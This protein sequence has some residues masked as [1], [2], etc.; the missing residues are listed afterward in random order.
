MSLR[1]TPGRAL[2]RD[3]QPRQ[4]DRLDLAGEGAADPLLGLLALD[5]GE[6]ADGAEVDAEDRDAGAGEAA[7]RVQDR[8][9]AAEDDAEVG[10]RLVA[11]DRLDAR[12]RVAVLGELVRGGDQ[13]PAGLG[14]DRG[15]DRHGLGGGRRV[16][17]GDQGRGL[18]R[19]T[20]T[21]A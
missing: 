12:G 9:V 11:G 4:L 8:A 2:Q 14:G 20:S 7:Q 5:R 18:H 6:E 15:G 13:P 16:R 10:A 3:L 21:A 1:P 19:S 17:V